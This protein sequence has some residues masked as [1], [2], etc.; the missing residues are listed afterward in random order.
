MS[1]R[2]TINAA[3]ELRRL[4]DQ[5]RPPSW[6]RKYPDEWTRAERATYNAGGFEP[7]VFFDWIVWAWGEDTCAPEAP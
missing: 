2:P 3:A 4:A 7:A 6:A 5:L 1:T